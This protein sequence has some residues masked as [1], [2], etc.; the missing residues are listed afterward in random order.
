M[1]SQRGGLSPVIATTLLIAMVVVLGLIVF[2]WFRGFA[3]ESCTKLGGTNVKLVCPD[4]NFESSYDP[5]S[6]ELFISNVGNIPIYRF[7]L[8]IEKS[9]S[10]DLKDITEIFSG[11]WPETGL[12][13]GGVFTGSISSFA[14][15]AQQITLIPVLL[16]KCESGE[17]SHICEDQYGMI[18][19]SNLG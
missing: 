1:L 6:G 8:K 5:V 12:N 13:S 19:Y 7:Q 11:T 2:L 9:G 4:V 17:K 16:G 14:S 10:T 3:E 15:D 18:I